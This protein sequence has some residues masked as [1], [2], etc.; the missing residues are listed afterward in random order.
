MRRAAV[1]EGIGIVAEPVAEGVQGGI[2]LAHGLAEFGVGVDALGAGHDFL[3]AHEEVVRVGQERV[4]WV[5]GG[6]EGSEGAREFVHGEEIGGVLLEND[7][8]EGFF[9]GSAGGGGLV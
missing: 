9:L 3:A 1:L 7:A 6:V 2:V 4:D 5:R 8:P